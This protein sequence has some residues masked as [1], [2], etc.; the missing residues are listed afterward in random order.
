MITEEKYEAVQRLIIS[1]IEEAGCSIDAADLLNRL[2]EENISRE[3]G[4]T[5]MWEM[6]GADY[7]SRSENWRLSPN[8]KLK[9]E[10]KISA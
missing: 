1:I 10:V 4:S 9:Q 7:L 6:V 2:R 3:V 5:I 8:R